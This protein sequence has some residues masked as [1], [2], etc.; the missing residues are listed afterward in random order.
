MR[1]FIQALSIFWV[2]SGPVLARAS[3]CSGLLATPVN[4]AELRHVAEASD[5]QLEIPN[6]MEQLDQCRSEVIDHDLSIVTK[7][8]E[9]EKLSRAKRRWESVLGVYFHGL[10]LSRRARRQ[11]A[12]E[13]SLTELRLA[14]R[15]KTW[16]LEDLE[17]RIEGLVFDELT[18]FDAYY[19]RLRTWRDAHASL[20]RAAEGLVRQL[21]TAR[22]EVTRA[23]SDAWTERRADI[24]YL[25]TR[26]TMRVNDHLERFFALTT[27]VDLS[28]EAKIAQ[29]EWNQFVLSRQARDLAAVA[30]RLIHVEG[31]VE[32]AGVAAAVV[33][34]R[35]NVRMNDI[36]LTVCGYVA[37]AAK[38][39]NS[40]SPAP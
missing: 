27:H 20:A 33:R 5:L 16:T 21:K 31:Q 35:L 19:D 24:G 29:V 4:R 38:S 17:K 7:E 22:A 34:D 6:L 26:I 23:Q 2:L 40:P 11:V 10:P 32:R 1:T 18:S 15:T 25:G 9:V 36:T 8:G 12:T 3:V 39:V 37:Q 14:Q 30:K 28:D 13:R